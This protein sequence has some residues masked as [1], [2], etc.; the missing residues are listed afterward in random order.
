MEFDFTKEPGLTLTKPFITED[1][2]PLVS[3]ITPYYNADKFFQ[4][5]FNCVINQTFPWFEWIIVDDGSTSEEALAQ[6]DIFASKDKRIQLMHK[7]NGG[8]ASA[9]NLGISA[10]HTDLII[11]LD[12]D[13]LI[14]PNYLEMNYW[15]LYFNPEASWSYTDSVGFQG[16]EYLWRKRFSCDVMKKDNQLTCTAMIHKKELIAIGCYEEVEKHYNE[17]WLAWLKLLAKGK[18][19]VHISEY[20][21]WYRRSDNGVLSI[22]KGNEEIKKRAFEVI[23]NAAN[24]VEQDVKAVE[25]PL[26]GTANTF[27]M[28]HRSN[29]TSIQPGD[30]DKKNILMILPWMEMG[31]ADLFNLD[32]VR[33]IDKSK[34]TI[35]VLTTNPG[36]NA[37]QQ[38]FQEHTSEIF[39]LPSFLKLENYAEFI[40]YFI[41]SRKIDLV[42]VSNSYL[43][44]HLVPWLRKEFS[45]VAI[46]DYVHM[47]EWY[48]RNGG[49][50]RL[51]GAMGDILEKTYVCNEKTRQVLI[52]DF[53]RNPENVKTVYIGVDQEKFKPAS[54]ACGKIKRKYNIPEQWHLILFPCRLHPQKRPFLMLEIAKRLSESNFPAAFV[55][56]GDGVQMDEMKRC[57]NNLN[58]NDRVYFAGRQKDLREYYEDASL[59]LICSLKEGLALTAYESLAIGT[60]VVTSDVGGQSELV[61]STVGAVIPLL[62]DENMDLDSRQFPEEEISLYVTAITDL[63]SDTVRYVEMRKACRNR[64]ESGFS[65]EIMISTLETEFEALLSEKMID[66]RTELSTGLK[67]VPAF[68]D[69]YFTLFQEYEKAKQEQEE[70]WASREW[71]RSLY[72][73]EQEKAQKLDQIYSMRA[74]KMVQKY[75][76]FMENN[77][78]GRF[79]ARVKNFIF[80]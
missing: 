41:K 25:F 54:T 48:W 26:C 45:D 65:T 70:V 50:A 6:L 75:V 23:Q 40:S 27:I 67:R 46:V 18:Y 47:E 9:R 73:K 3:I 16:Q 10:A 28:P 19:P 42:M 34:Y 64:I 17:D 13:D 56:V 49:Y 39:N 2:L 76:S 52:N 44:Y 80:K 8:I 24:R 30:S 74:W 22:V 57:V 63:L 38:R 11:P 5:T 15:G 21:F 37:W 32:V 61:N 62:Q 66:N 1:I 29:W 51:S 14:M 7:K 33:K 43:G 58:L 69:D 59:T 4:Q 31:G 35:S 12:A 78:F 36:E 77:K 72:E 53:G 79:L 68:I 55:I 60:P 71:F 20:S